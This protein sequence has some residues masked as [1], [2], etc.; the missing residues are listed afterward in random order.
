LA[1]L[2]GTEL[3][4]GLELAK[5]RFDFVLVALLV[6]TVLSI[7]GLLLSALFAILTIVPRLHLEQPKSHFFFCHLVEL[8]ERRFHAAEKALIA[9][10]ED[11]MLHQLA[12]Q[13]QTNAVICDV[14]ASRSM[15]AP[16]G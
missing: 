1:G 3:V 13:V 8:Y 9:L 6:I 5:W 10:T 2:L 14:K 7:V 16:Y 11:Q 12:S 4:K 15:R